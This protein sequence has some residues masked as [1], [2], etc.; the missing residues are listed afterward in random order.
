ME[1]L[2]TLMLMGIAVAFVCSCKQHK[3]ATSEN[4]SYKNDSIP[5]YPIQSFLQSQ[6][7]Q[8][9]Q[10]PYF[11]YKIHTEG[12]QRD[13]TVITSQ[14][15]AMEA[16]LFT[17]W[18][19]GDTATKKYYKEDAFSDESIQSITLSYTTHNRE[20]PVQHADVLLVPET[21][22]VKRI[23]MDLVQQAGDTTITYK[24]GWK[25][26]HSY[27]IAKITHLP[28]GKEYNSQTTVVWN[29]ND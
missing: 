28:N 27:S 9:I 12:Q 20:L 25:V 29:E 24:L 2:F 21:R 18:S 1:R 10:T 22:K 15:F 7:Q 8:V 17:A 16:G 19:I 5:F 14:Q 11:I 23:F 6:I 26:N 13:S 4:I 3:K